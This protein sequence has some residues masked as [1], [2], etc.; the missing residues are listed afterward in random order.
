MLR[1]MLS[2]RWRPGSVA[3]IIEA[4]L[5]GVGGGILRSVDRSFTWERGR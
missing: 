5:H 4:D 1:R 2:E 3:R